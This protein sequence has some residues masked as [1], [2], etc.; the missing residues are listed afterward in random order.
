MKYRFRT[1]PYAHQV[2]ALRKLLSEPAKW[3]GGGLPMDT[4]TGKTKVAIDYA[5]IKELTGEIDQVL[6]AAPLS[7]L[8]VWDREIMKHA[9]KTSKLKWKT[10]NYDRI[11]I[12]DYTISRGPGAGTHVHVDHFTPLVKW[13]EKGKTLLICD[14]SHELKEATSKTSRGCHVLSKVCYLA[15]WT[16]GT[17]DD[18]DP[19]DYYGQ[20]RLIDDGILGSSWGVF[21]RTYAIWGGYGGFKRIKYQNLRQLRTR[22][23]PYIFP[24]KKEDCLDLPPWR[25]EVIPVQLEESRAIYE[26]LAKEAIVTVEDEEF[27]AAH[28]FSM[29]TRCSQLTGGWLKNDTTKKHVGREK[30]RV[31]TDHLHL[32]WENKIGKA[33]IFADYLDDLRTSIR[34]CREVGYRVLP[35]YGGVPKD[36]RERFLAKFDEAD[37]RYVMVVQIRTGSQS[38]SMTAANHVIFFGHTFSLI[39]HTQ[40]LGRTDRIGQKSPGMY[41]H[42]VAEDT[43]DELKWLALESKTKVS[44]L[45]RRHPELII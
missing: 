36:R 16:T 23:E 2:D 42:L 6:V 18:G 20:M 26:K 43:V 21:K 38:V 32:A 34:A 3:H 44:E 4:G 22:V 39:R 41:Y 29:L 9:P 15:L 10:V 8:G 31:L 25:H 5:C 19:L 13:C 1:K 14:E 45:F 12:R 28:V 37:E 33:V 30:E 27:K 17:P 24:I 7:A 35:F 11:P 40:A